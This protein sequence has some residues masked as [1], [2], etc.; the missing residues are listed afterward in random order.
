MKKIVIYSLICS[1]IILGNK[2]EM[3]P[4]ETS[5]LS[6]ENGGNKYAIE[7]YSDG[8]GI[9]TVGKF[10]IDNNPM[11]SLVFKYGE[12]ALLKGETLKDYVLNNGNDSDKVLAL[13]LGNLAKNIIPSDGT[14]CNDK[15]SQTINDIY[16]NGNCFGENVEGQTCNDENSQTINDIYVNGV[17][18][19]TNVEGQTCNDNDAKTINDIYV[20]GVCKGELPKTC[21][22]YKQANPTAVNGTYTID[23]DGINT[24]VSSFN[25]YCDMTNGGWTRVGYKANVA[26]A[27]RWT[28]GDAFRYLPSNF[29]L[30][31]TSA[32]INA[33]RSA[34]TQAKQTLI[35]NCKGVI[36]YYYTSGKSYK[37]GAGF[38]FQTGVESSKGLSTYTPSTISVSSD[39]CAANDSVSRR[40]TF[41]INNLNLPIINVGTTDNGNSGEE[42]GFTTLTNN[43]AWFK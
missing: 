42:F 37:Y 9:Y 31:F 11:N 43:P 27:N 16:I 12:E 24:G 33:I 26:L 32:Q 39:G 7:A 28:T 4:L 34:S 36:M 20:N 5:N 29:S 10:N 40:T 35:A 38:K 3:I 25:V 2:L 22:Y 30:E 18:I 17:C 1:S 8:I 6:L 14:S 15:N 19:G 13:E 41:N 21:Y 23:P